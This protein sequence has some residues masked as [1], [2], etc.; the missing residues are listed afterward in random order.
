MTSWIMALILSC[1]TGFGAPQADDEEVALKVRINAAIDRGVDNLLNHQHRDGSWTGARFGAYKAG[2]TAF[3]A[4]T[5]V[6][7]GVSIDA[8]AIRLALAYLKEHP[9]K[10]TY[11]AGS[12]LMLLAEIHAQRPLSGELKDLAVD[13][14]E[15]IIA[16]ES[17]TIPGSWGY[18]G[19]PLDLSC[20]Q[21][22][23]L[24]LLAADRIGLKVPLETMQKTALTVA[25][26]Y[27]DEPV[28][29]PVHLASRGKK[30]GPKPFIA[31]YAYKP[32]NKEMVRGSMTVAG[33]GILEIC[34]MVSG[35]KLGRKA[36]K[37]SEDSIELGM[38]WLEANWTLTENVR[39]DKGGTKPLFYLWGVE[40]LAAFL[41]TDEFFG[42]QWYEPGA[43]TILDLEKDKKGTWGH[44]DESCLALLFLNRATRAAVSGRKKA[45]VETKWNQNEGEV[46]FR[47]TGNMDATAWITDLE[48]NDPIASVEW[49]LDG[50]SHAKLKGDGKKSWKGERFP[51]RWSE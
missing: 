24:G 15:Q 33:L 46:K 36:I 43:V 1:A 8:P 11:S 22:A 21:F 14:F 10:M 16:W 25:T 44:Y 5:L 12:V 19:P 30:R 45:S 50:E 51:T 41:D 29:S 23:A 48:R 4:Y 35:R 28:R 18:P 39:A 32:G 40:R 34:R 2:P 31:G 37:A 17:T 38:G 47:V 27:Q 6:E 9:S 3:T 42:F 13:T 26:L 49:L 7:S 20:T